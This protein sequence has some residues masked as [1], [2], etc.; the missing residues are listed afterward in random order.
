[1]LDEDNRQMKILQ[2]VFFEDGEL[3]GQGRERKF[4]WLNNGKLVGFFIGLFMIY[5]THFV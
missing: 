2:E 3:H 1:M 5:L 4:R